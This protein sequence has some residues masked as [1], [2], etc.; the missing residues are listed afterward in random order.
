MSLR[1]LAHTETSA[2]AD[3]FAYLREGM[4]QGRRML[5]LTYLL[6]PVDL[7]EVAYLSELQNLAV[8][9]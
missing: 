6:C 3:L 4:R 1:Y 8:L 7:R 2:D 5:V 9:P